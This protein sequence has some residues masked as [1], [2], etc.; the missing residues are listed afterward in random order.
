MRCPK[1]V[2]VSCLVI[3]LTSSAQAAV[4]KVPSGYPTVQTGIDAARNGDT[5]LV[6]NGTYRGTGNRELDFK[7]KAIIVESENGA[8]S[9]IIDCQGGGRG[10]YFHTGETSASVL[11]GFT[12]KNGSPADGYGGAIYCM[13]SSSPTIENNVITGNSATSNGSGIFCYDRSSPIIRN[14]EITRNSTRGN[15]GGIYC[16]NSSSPVIQG[17]IITENSADRYGG[18]ISCYSNSS[19]VIRGNTITG[20]ASS[21][22][23]GGIYCEDNSSPTI[24]NN[25][26]NRNRATRD[27]G[28]IHCFTDSSPII[29]GNTISENESGNYGGGISSQRGAFPTIQNNEISNNSADRNGGG[30]ACQS[31]SS[32]TIQ[33][34]RIKGN[35]AGNYGGGV[36]CDSTSPATVKNNEITKNVA[37]EYGGGMYSASSLT[38]I[39]NTISGNRANGRF[40]GGYYC[41]GGTAVILNTIIWGD[42]PKGIYVVAEASVNITYSDIE[43]GWAGEGNIQADPM[44]VNAAG[45]DYRLSRNSPCISAGKADESVPAKDIEGKTRVAPPDMGAYES[46]PTPIRGDVNNDGK[47]RSDD[48]ILTLQIAVGKRQPN[49]YQK[50]AADMN[51]DGKI[52]SDDAILVLRKAAGISA[53]GMVTRRR[54]DA[55]T[56]RTNLSLDEAYSLAGERVTVPLRVDNP[57]GLAG[58]DILLVYDSEVLRAVDVLFEADMLTVSNISEPGMVRIAFAGV[59]KLDSGTLA[60]ISFD[61]IADDISPLKIER[62][63]LYGPDAFP[64]IS[65]CI[66]REFRSWAVAPE[67]SALLQNFPNPFNPETWISYQLKEASEV[68]IRIYNAAGE[69][70]RELDL[71]SKPAGIYVT[72]GRAAYWDG[73][74]ASGEEVASGVY[75]YSIRAGDFSAVRKLTVLR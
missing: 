23:G 54:G 13:N 16:Y 52:R 21:L 26:I 44:F 25:S 36:Y 29:Q 37:S 22:Y 32:A 68:R 17:N 56:R 71:G 47:V 19:P 62:A 12:I 53:P 73:R 43:G 20:N 69:L 48:A 59:G 27:G 72:Q 51:G 45:G 40:G 64:L 4:I 8:G 67:R 66:D 10:F 14:N 49:E 6:A 74:N 35:S 24:E 1:I 7:G 15:A 70:V 5:V 61:V 31:V 42:S 9:T 50:W 60:R 63:E 38:A 39:N 41:G 2:L 55:E 18:G 3:I 58:G 30:I 11:R 57:T 28:G 46:K 75:F 34:N 65:R 33:N